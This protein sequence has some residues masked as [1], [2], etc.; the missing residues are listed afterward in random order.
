MTLKTGQNQLHQAYLLALV[1]GTMS[2]IHSTAPMQRLIIEYAYTLM[3]ALPQTRTE[4]PALLG[5]AKLTI[6]S[7]MDYNIKL[8]RFL[9]YQA[10]LTERW[11]SLRLSTGR[12]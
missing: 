7:P 9:M 12:H 8:A 6:C 3:E 4:Q 1:F 5:I 2:Y 11:R 10:I